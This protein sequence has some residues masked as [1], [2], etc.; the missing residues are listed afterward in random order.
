MTL[1]G[2]PD[3]TQRYQKLNQKNDFLIRLNKI[4]PW[5]EFRPLLEKIRQKPRKSNAGRKPID[6]VLMF[7]LLVLQKLYNIGDDQLEYQ[8][9]DRL[10]FMQF[11]GLSLADDVP[12]A[13]TVWLFRQ[14]IR[15]AGL[16]EELFEQFEIYLQS[17]GYQ[18]KGGQMLDA[19][20]VPVPKQHISK[21]EKKQ[22]DQGEIP[23]DW[24]ENPHR[25]SQRDM[26]ASWTKKNNVSH[27]GYKN[28]IS[29]DVEYGF[30]RCYSVTDAAVHDS[31]TLPNI[32]DEDNEGDGIWADSAYRSALI[33]WFL[34]VLNW[35]SH[36]H[37]RGY[38]N[39]PLTEQQKENNREKSKIRAKVAHVFGAWVNEMGGKLA[40][41]IG[42]ERARAHLG[43]QNLA[44][45]L[46]RYVYLETRAAQAK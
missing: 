4:V 23:P 2:L 10:S 26:D 29:V 12:D 36:I 46:K 35:C 41:S 38:R 9:N 40:R 44:Y 18:A 5:E 43:V 8:V 13:T 22:L 11:L 1:A 20:I 32:L 16:I 45:N 28:H 15:S 37:E 33:E 27:F 39:H 17:H 25:L 6:V 31:Q 19:T 30:V 34:G 24:Q 14:Q 21:E 3:L 42:L 7:K